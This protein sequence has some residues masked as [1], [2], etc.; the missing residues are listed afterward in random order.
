VKHK[1]GNPKDNVTKDSTI[2]IQSP[3]AAE[4]T[5]ANADSKPAAKH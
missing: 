1:E 4:T 3:T 5:N 2:I